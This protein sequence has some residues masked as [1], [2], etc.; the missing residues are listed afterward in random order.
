MERLV[1]NAFTI[2]LAFPCVKLN[3]TSLDNILNDEQ[4]PPLYPNVTVVSISLYIIDMYSVSE[5]DMTFKLKYYFNLKWLDPKLM[6]NPN[7]YSK[8]KYI[9]SSDNSKKKGLFL[10]VNV[11]NMVQTAWFPNIFIVNLIPTDHEHLNYKNGIAKLKSNGEIMFIK[12][13]TSSLRCQM[14]L[15]KLPFDT[16]HCSVLFESFKYTY[17][18]LLIEWYPIFKH[19]GII[20]RDNLTL[21]DFEII[22][23]F[24]SPETDDVQSFNAVYC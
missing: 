4:K 18:E 19:Q 17:K 15:Q 7:G 12:I 10:D 6:F 8:K 11:D 9:N 2:L 23:K 14:D 16:Q 21:N 5:Q 3:R 1:F 20:S 13:V 22:G 24:F